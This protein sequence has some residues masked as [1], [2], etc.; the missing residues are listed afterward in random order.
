MGQRRRS[1]DLID[2]LARHVISV[3]GLCVI[4]AVL[5]IIFFILREGL[6]LFYPAKSSPQPPLPIP[7]QA[8]QG[9]TSLL[10]TSD[11]YREF[12]VTLDR[13]GVVRLRSPQDGALKQELRTPLLKG[14]VLTA[15]SEPTM[16][17]FIAATE[18]GLVVPLRLQ[19]QVRWEGGRRVLQ[20][21]L[22]GGPV[23]DF[24]RPEDPIRKVSGA[25]LE[26]GGAQ[27]AIVTASGELL[28]GVFNA[29]EEKT[30]IFRLTDEVSPRRLSALAMSS[31]GEWLVAGAEEGTFNVW[32][33]EAGEAPSRIQSSEASAAPITALAFLLGDESLIV[34]D[35]AG[36]VAV[37]FPLRYLQVANTAEAPVRFEGTL[38][39]PGEQQRILDRGYATEYSHIPALTFT[40]AGRSFRK[41]H[42]FAPH[43]HGVTALAASSRNRGFISADTAGGVWLRYATTESTQARLHAGKDAI[44]SVAFSPRLDGIFALDAAGRV[45]RWSLQN[46][47][48]DATLE[49]LFTKVWYEGAMESAHVWQST[50][51]SDAFEPKYGLWPLLF[52]TFKGT[53]Y[54]MIFSVPLAIVAALYLS[55]LGPSRLRDVC[56]PVIEI[57]A[58]LPSVV[59][60]FLAALWFAPL[61]SQHL[62]TALL[63]LLLMP[64]C[65]G[66][67]LGVWYLT[68][69][70]LR[71]TLRPGVELVFIFA[72]FVVAFLIASSL[73]PFLENAFLGKD[74]AT[75]LFERFG[76]VYDQRNNIVVGVALGFAV[77]P[78]IFSICEDAMCSVPPAYTSAALALG[79]S[80][81]QTAIYVVLPAASPGI[82]A[83]ILLGLGRAV[84]ETMI[85]LMATGNTPILDLSPFTG[86]RTMSAT[87]AVEIPEA[88]YGGTLYRVLFATGFLLFAITF[89]INTI[90]DTVSYRLRRRYGRY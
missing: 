9:A 19:F 5:A 59:V 50:G 32:Q 62:A 85:V 72:A 83:A 51:G 37:W 31:N 38:L 66:A 10:V 8:G 15:A 4:V 63:W 14:E 27:A 1:A 23:L 49:N 57:M 29:V 47:H 26:G 78:L 20:P 12:V 81:W 89:M 73:G 90:A 77:I 2:S 69:K 39:R 67:A 3:G 61:V 18:S 53:F 74:L 79:A 75:W 60:G 45:H 11:E 17:S 82:F 33:L 28:Y 58:A 86:M 35:A 70:V 21:R 42:T 54:A 24:E 87:I 46:S 68:A 41:I 65:L 71:A 64:P 22:S 16:G 44:R 43:P 25:R 36:G 80:K 34:G 30:T 6:P 56:K 48:P 40:T 13:D 88:A 84:G 76:I 55:Q 7:L 52:G